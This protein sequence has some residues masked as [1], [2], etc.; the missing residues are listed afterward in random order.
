MSSRFQRGVIVFVNLT[1]L[2]EN[3]KKSFYQN[4]TPHLTNKVKAAWSVVKDLSNRL[5]NRC[6][7]NK[8]RWHRQINSTIFCQIC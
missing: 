3:K 5:N 2:I 1:T 6:C 7:E 8:R 4:E